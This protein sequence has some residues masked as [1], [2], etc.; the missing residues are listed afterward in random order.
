[1]RDNFCFSCIY[2]NFFFSR[3][4]PR[5]SEIICKD[6]DGNKLSKKIIFSYYLYGYI[7]I[8]NYYI[9]FIV[10]KLFL[11]G[12]LETIFFSSFCAFLQKKLWLLSVDYSMYRELYVHKILCMIESTSG[13]IK[14]VLWIF[15]LITAKK[16]V[17][18]WSMCTIS[19]YLFIIWT[20]Y[21]VNLFCMAL[22]DSYQLGNF[23]SKCLNWNLTQIKWRSF[24]NR[25]INT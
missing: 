2:P 18:M 14:N 17:L 24:I 15:L 10:K 1:M 25:L 23:W 6:N 20:L 12:D 3:F 9:Q 8:S 16:I 22:G 7:C 19:C 5:K 4:G 21:A 13:S 11:F